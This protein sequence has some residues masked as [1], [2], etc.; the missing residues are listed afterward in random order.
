MSRFCELFR[1]AELQ[2]AGPEGLGGSS[3]CLAA[4]GTPWYL[5]YFC[6]CSFY[7]QSPWSLKRLRL[8]IEVR[9]ST[10]NPAILVVKKSGHT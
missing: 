7:P 9:L 5:S 1:A 6:T 8:V 10:V 2:G 3:H 4:P